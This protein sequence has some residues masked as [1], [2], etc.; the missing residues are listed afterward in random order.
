MEIHSEGTRD[1][2][3]VHSGRGHTVRHPPTIP[4]AYSNEWRC[5]E[6][7][8]FEHGVRTWQTQA[9]LSDKC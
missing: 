3:H 1:R 2:I 8:V 7:S 9:D 6:M 5:Q 4:L